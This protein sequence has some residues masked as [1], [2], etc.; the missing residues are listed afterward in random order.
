MLERP[1]RVKQIRPLALAAGPCENPRMSGRRSLAVCPREARSVLTV[2]LAVLAGVFGCD[3]TITGIG[4]V[5]RPP[6]AQLPPAP[7]ESVDRGGD[8][9]AVIRPAEIAAQHLLVMY[10]GSRAAPKSIKRTK[11]EARARA[12]E[13]LQRIKAG[14][15]FDQ[16]VAAYTD[17]PGGAARHGSLGRFSYD[18]M[19]KAFSDAAFALEVGQVSTVIETAFGFHVIRRTE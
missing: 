10:D 8:G 7:V 13:A 1:F 15:P 4:R 5:P 19:V 14:E 17:E 3:G 18:Q 9:G 2:A 12:A 11:E 16:V 6:E